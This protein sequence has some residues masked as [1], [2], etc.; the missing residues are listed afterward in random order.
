[1]SILIG[2]C[3]CDLHAH[4]CPHNNLRLF[5]VVVQELNYVLIYVPYRNVWPEVVYCCFTR[6]TLF[7]V[8]ML[9]ST[10]LLLFITSPNFIAL[11]LVSE[12]VNVLA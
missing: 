8:Y 6:P 5:I 3:V 12:V 7:T 1:M 9:L 4:L 2:F 11:H 10:Q